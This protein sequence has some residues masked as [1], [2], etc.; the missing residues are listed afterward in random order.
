[1]AYTWS[2]ELD[3]VAGTASHIGAV[4]GN[5]NPF[6]GGLDKGL[7]AVDRAHVFHAT[8]VWGLPIGKGH[9][10]GSGNAFARG[11]A[12]GWQLSGI[13]TFTTGIPLAIVG[14]GCNTPGIVSTC[15]ASYN[16]S[17]PGAVRINGSYG[18]GNALSPGAVSY[19]AK[20]AFADPAAY[21]FGTLPRS[22]PYGLFAP[23]LLDESLSLRREIAI[24]ERLKLAI[25][26]EVFNLTNSVYFGAPGNN[27]DSA[28]FGQVT[29]SANLPRKLQLNARITF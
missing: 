6:A 20:N 7:G 27:I 21:T 5:R 22:A 2:K 12:S 9:A 19:F 11:L 25:T 16:P 8:F 3:N 14:S 24:T 18:S 17:Y 1:V 29:T 4:G 15:I 10:I 28:N 23:S 26:G 13:I